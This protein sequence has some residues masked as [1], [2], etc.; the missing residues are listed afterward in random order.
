[1]DTSLKENIA[2]VSAVFHQHRDYPIVYAKLGQQFGGF[3][4]LW[5]Y[6]VYLAE[7]FTAVEVKDD[8]DWD[9]EW[10]DAIDRYVDSV[11][12]KMVNGTTPGGYELWT[13]VR[14]AI[15]YATLLKE[16]SGQ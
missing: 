6:C 11:V 15:A 12:E 1:M 9:G 16:R 7:E 2:A 5:K 8:T 4:G 13:L 10:I 3:P 14:E